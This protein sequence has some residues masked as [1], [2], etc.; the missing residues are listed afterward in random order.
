MASYISKTSSDW[1]DLRTNE[2]S[3]D[4]TSK[5]TDNH[6]TN[7]EDDTQ[8]V[9]VSNKKNRSNKFNKDI[10]N[11]STNYITVDIENNQAKYNSKPRPVRI[12]D[13]NALKPKDS[14]KLWAKSGKK[15]DE[16]IAY[17]M[18]NKDIWE[19][20]DFVEDN[21]TLM[22]DELSKYWRHDV[23]EKLKE[24]SS[25]FHNCESHYNY[26]K[27]TPYHKLVWPSDKVGPKIDDDK[28]FEIK[29]TFY[30]LVKMGFRMF[31]VN[32]KFPELNEIFL[33]ALYGSRNS[34]SNH[35]KDILYEFFT[36]TFT[37]LPYF[38]NYQLTDV[39]NVSKL[40][41]TQ[42]NDKVLYLV[43]K[44]KDSIIKPIAYNMFDLGVCEDKNNGGREYIRNIC[45]AVILTPS[46]SENYYKYL[47][48]YNIEEIKTYFIST[49]ISSYS[50]W[51]KDS[52]EPKNCNSVL[53]QTT[54]LKSAYSN[55]VIV[56]AVFYKN[57][58]L[59]DEII[60]HMISF[61]DQDIIKIPTHVKYFFEES[62]MDFNSMSESEK[63]FVLKFI[64][65]YYTNPSD[66]NSEFRSD[67][68]VAF[69]NWTG[70][71]NM[72][73]VIKKIN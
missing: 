9:S 8:W 36:E 40:N 29:R 12:N 64:D 5:S 31:K 66:K 35:Y 25:Y 59:R 47:S 33:G 41:P 57:N 7:I 11:S 28:I 55:A 62:N 53:Q 48:K 39:L 19:R 46:S 60:E 16:M 17:Y 21:L 24:K 15:T 6:E 14:I 68:I 49:F 44:Y 73:E 67:V 3:N 72:S 51:I 70:I 45:K 26:E 27:L 4:D 10:V 34:I 52:L 54:Y 61:L 56:L 32:K 13:P 37:N 1:E 42:V 43:H 58:Y 38:L 22:V 63:K 50:K 18:S 69:K 23:L 71:K 2:T 65:M 30:E 20:R